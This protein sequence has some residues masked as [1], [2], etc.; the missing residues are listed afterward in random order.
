MLASRYSKTKSSEETVKILLEH[1]ANVNIQGINPLKCRYGYGWTAL[2]Y[3]SVNLKNSSSKQ[4]VRM[5]LEHGADLNIKVEGIKLITYLYNCYRRNEI[6]AEIIGLLI[7]FGANFSDLP[8]DRN[9]EN[10]LVEKRYLKN[11]SHNVIEYINRADVN[12]LNSICE[13]C[14]DDNIKV[15]ECDKRHKICLRC[16][17]KLNF[18]C[19][20]CH[21]RT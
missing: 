14:Y 15:T 21:P 10:I 19:E 7:T 11:E 12:I 2:T 20:F 4:T 5:L 9:L 1:G 3:A 8:V 17:I 16:I 18:K 13:I 6:D